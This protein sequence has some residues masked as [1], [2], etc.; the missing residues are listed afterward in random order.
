MPGKSVVLVT[1]ANGYIAGQTIL[2]LLEAG[3][4]VRGIVRSKTSA[5]PLIEALVDKGSDL[6]IVEVPDIVSPGAFDSVVQGMSIDP[7]IQHRT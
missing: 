6:E 2:S 5:E 3:Y 7:S 4:A 1:G